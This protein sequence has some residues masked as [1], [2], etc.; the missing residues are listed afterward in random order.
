MKFKVINGL[1]WPDRCHVHQD[2]FVDN[3]IIFK[4]FPIELLSRINL[5]LLKE[6]LDPF[7][8]NAV[9]GFS[10]PNHP[11]HYVNHIMFPPNIFQ[12]IDYE[13]FKKKEEAELYSLTKPLVSYMTEQINLKFKNSVP[14]Y[15]E[16]NILNPNISIGRHTDH[17]QGVGV[18]F[19]MHMVLST[20]DLVEF[21]IEGKKYYFP[22]G[23]C[24]IFNNTKEH[25][26]YN[27]HPE[28]SR[29]HLIVDF[30]VKS[31]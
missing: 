17:H 29:I 18:N 21:I 26:V 30:S 28:L 12:K 6:G 19:R 9:P 31:T 20:N 27:R 15:S 11:F 1:T 22:Q 5:F 3:L 4:S 16:I 14:V 24:F 8:H 23:S 10:L 7:L 25:E 2:K 13:I